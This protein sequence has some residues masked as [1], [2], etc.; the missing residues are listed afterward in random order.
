VEPVSRRRWDSRETQSSL[1]VIRGISETLGLSLLTVRTLLTRG[2]TT[3]DEGRDFLEGRLATLPDPFLFDGMDKAVDR[4]VHAV[5][6]GE[7]IA[8]HGDYDVDGITAVTLLVETLCSFGANVDYHIPLRLKDGYGLSGEALE[9][10]ASSGVRVVVSVDCGVSAIEE[11]RLASSLGLDLVIT[12]HHLPPETLPEAFAIINPRKSGCPFPFKD[13]AGVGVAFF[14][15]AALR[16][17]LREMGYFE[18]K[19][20]PD[21]RRSLDLVALGTIADIVPLRGINR[22]LVRNGLAAITRGDR[23]GLQALKDVSGVKEASCG[24]VGFRLAPRLNAAG[25][26]EDA[27]LGTELLLE[28][29]YS[30]ALETARILDAF[31]AERQKIEMETLN[32]AIDRLE[33][34]REGGTTSIVLGDERWHPGVIGIVASRLVERYHRPSVLIAM[35]N[36]KGKGSA[37]SIRGLHLYE[38]LHLCRDYLDGFGGHEFAAGL[39]I[40]SDRIG[41]FTFAFEEVAR[42]RLDDEDLIPCLFHDGEVLLEELTSEVVGELEGLAPF[43]S[44]NPEPLFLTRR[45]KAQQIRV[46]GEK[47]LRFTVRQGGYSSVCIAFGMADRLRELEGEIDLLHS[48]EINLWQ[49]QVSVQL[50]VKDFRAAEG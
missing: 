17:R 32:Q 21:L 41:D 43:G 49:G 30:K 6:E 45:V 23:P 3:S 9:S 18:D 19:D 37:R 29:S 28:G 34:G 4:I 12:D 5:K 13:L 48:P 22:I 42:G 36:G 31:N 10:A 16:K 40:S 8:I 50:K 39:T 47:H 26:L 38:A 33:R 7:K 25:R 15:M 46:V 14:L 44:G 20:E 35:E 27:S 11:A 24:A 2:V 1:T